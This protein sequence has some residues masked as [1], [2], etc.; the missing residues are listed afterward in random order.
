MIE[1][2]ERLW[3]EYFAEE[4]ALIETEEERKQVKKVKELRRNSFRIS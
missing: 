2:F 3:N 4:C 1:I